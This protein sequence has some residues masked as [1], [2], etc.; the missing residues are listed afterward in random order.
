MMVGV[1]VVG[2][3]NQPCPLTSRHSEHGDIT[4]KRRHRI[5]ECTRFL[6]TSRRVRF[7][8]EEECDWLVGEVRGQGGWDVDARWG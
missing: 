4:T 1:G 6:G 2:N 3:L 5:T 7:R 8:E